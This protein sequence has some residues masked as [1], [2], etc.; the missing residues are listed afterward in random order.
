MAQPTNRKFYDTCATCPECDGLFRDAKKKF[1]T[2]TAFGKIV[3]ENG[4][5]GGYGLRECPL[6]SHEPNSKARKAA[7]EA[8]ERLDAVSS[9][10]VISPAQMK[11]KLEEWTKGNLPLEAVFH[12]NQ[13]GQLVL[14]TMLKVNRETGEV[15]F[16]NAARDIPPPK[17]QE[18]E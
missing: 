7:R 1:P 12:V 15:G 5:L 14:Y 9:V 6:S 16:M 10:P 2:H 18:E 8:L 13:H 3:H 11:V 4:V 17:G